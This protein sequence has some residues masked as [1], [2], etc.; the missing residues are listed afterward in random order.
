M[1]DPSEAEMLALEKIVWQT[2]VSGDAEIDAGLL[3]D[4]FLGVYESGF[5]DKAGHVGQLADGPTVE[6]YALSDVRLMLPGDGLALLSYRA[7]FE[8]CGSDRAEAMYVSSLWQRQRTGWR[9][10][11]SQD[12]PATD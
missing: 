1:A 3:S 12:T 11:F 4:D 8:R 10:I 6:K 5:S 9:N 2:L 7:D